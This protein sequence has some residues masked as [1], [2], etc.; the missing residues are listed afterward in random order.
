MQTK[1]EDS[2]RSGPALRNPT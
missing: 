1:L 2:A